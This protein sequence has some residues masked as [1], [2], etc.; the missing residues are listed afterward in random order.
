VARNV[1]RRC[2][3]SY[4]EAGGWHFESFTWS[5]VRWTVSGKRVKNCRWM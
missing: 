2:D 5:K 1:S 4:L 3:A